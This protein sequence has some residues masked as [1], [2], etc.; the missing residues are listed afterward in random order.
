MGDQRYLVQQWTGGTECDLTGKPRSIEIQFHCDMQTNDRISM[1]QEVATCQ[2]QMTITTPRLC[3]EMMLASTS[4]SDVNK[5]ECNPIVP[6]HLVEET[7]TTP[8]DETMTTTTSDSSSSS[9]VSGKDF[10]QATTTTTTTT[11]TA[12]TTM[13]WQDP[14]TSNPE[15]EESK[16]LD[17]SKESLLDAVAELKAQLQELRQQVQQ[18]RHDRSATT[19]SQLEHLLRGVTGG[20][21]GGDAV[22]AGDDGDIEFLVYQVDENGELV[23]A[24]GGGGLDQLFTGQQEEENKDE[25][26]EG[27]QRQNKRAYEM[28]YL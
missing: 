3:E 27:S 1:F 19:L 13:T 24:E 2:Y 8:M 18:Q 4:H 7:T 17:M 16:P 26:E 9:A 25:E 15:Q 22:V 28:R 20:A 5:I 23:A 12:T 14:S 21:G 10:S 11:D 6:D